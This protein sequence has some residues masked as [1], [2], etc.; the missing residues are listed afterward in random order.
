M[1]R[2][3]RQTKREISE[4]DQAFYKLGVMDG[5]DRLKRT[6]KLL[7]TTNRALWDELTRLDRA[8]PLAS[9]GV[10][11]SFA[12]MERIIEILKR[13]KTRIALAR[14]MKMMQRKAK[15]KAGML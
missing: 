6:I 13:G 3:L 8:E 7:K 2:K 15:K 12:D 11:I 1:G 4:T 5:E 9:S 14:K 10:T